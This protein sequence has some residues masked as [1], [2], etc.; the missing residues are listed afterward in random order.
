[1]ITASIA[2]LAI[3]V[4]LVL[5][6]TVLLLI[7]T[8][9]RSLHKWVCLARSFLA[10]DIGPGGVAKLLIVFALS[11][12]AAAV[13][14]SLKGDGK[15]ID[16]VFFWT[17]FGVVTI[18]NLVGAFVGH[19][20]TFSR[21][22]SPGAGSHFREKRKT[23]TAAILKRIN[24]ILVSDG[25]S[26]DQVKNTLSDLLDV[27]VLHVSDHRGS[28]RKDKPEVFANILLD[29]GED[30]VVVARDRLSQSPGYPR[31]TPTKHAKASTACGRA[32][33]ARKPISVGDLTA[34]YPEAP[35]NKPYRSILALPLISSDDAQVY[36]ALSIDS[37]RP[38]FF[39]SF[40]EGHVENYLENSLQPYIQSGILLIE[41]LVGRDRKA[42][43]S[44]LYEA[45]ADDHPGDGGESRA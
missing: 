14:K 34:E 10:I 6:L 26:I 35:K 9:R 7:T 44:K 28:Y 18:T 31:P 38:Y 19:S 40:R 1:M 42:I 25:P 36:G 24:L 5:L 33:E 45:G 2:L 41:T 23:A 11:G 8:T 21:I 32:I 17:I 27:I 30:L 22:L 29:A 39:H 4:F 15:G 37:S 13:A 12:L 20:T 43:L 16:W 3:G